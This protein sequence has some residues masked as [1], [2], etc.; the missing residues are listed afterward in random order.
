M[1]FVK[2]ARRASRHGKHSRTVAARYASKF[3]LRHTVAGA[4]EAVETI[5]TFGRVD[6]SVR[7][8]RDRLRRIV[9]RRIEVREIV[10]LRVDWLAILVT[11]AEL[12]TQLAIHFP[13]V[14]D[15]RFGLRE[16][17]KAHRIEGLFAVRSE[18]SEQ[19][20]GERVVRR[21]SV[22]AGIEVDLAR[23]NRA[24]VWIDAIARD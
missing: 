8:N 7:E 23:V 9:T 2:S 3:F 16:T 22:A 12:E 17:E 13:T 4:H 11:H 19:R 15:K 1:T 24:G 21:A 14:C 5:A 20:I 10:G 6:V 18:I